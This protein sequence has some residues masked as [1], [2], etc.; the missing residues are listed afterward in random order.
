MASSDFSMQLYTETPGAC[1]CYSTVKNMT[2]LEHTHLE[3]ELLFVLEGN[4]DV[5]I[6]N[7]KIK[8]V[9]NDLIFI[10]NN[11]PHS[12]VTQNSSVS[13]VLACSPSEVPRFTQLV[14]TQGSTSCCLKSDGSLYP[15]IHSLTD[16]RVSSQN[17]YTFTGYINMLLSHVSTA[18][19]HQP[20]QAP[21][22]ITPYNLVLNYISD[23]F[24]DTTEESIA[25]E[26]GMSK[27]ALSRLFNQNMGCNLR[28]YISS[29]RINTAHRMLVQT[30]LPINEIALRCGYSSPRSFNRDFLRFSGIQPRECRNI[31]RQEKMVNYQTPIVN[32][33]LLKKW[34]SPDFT[35]YPP[36]NIFYLSPSA[37]Q[38]PA[39]S[40]PSRR[41][42]S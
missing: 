35:D 25:N 16:T 3:Y 21:R 23:H 36:E 13:L 8:A 14:Q 9:P 2:Y 38:N 6:L 28:T 22:E 19:S 10:A 42:Q 18:L 20:R 34:T 7:H 32:E 27:Y 40:R 31:E 33:I 30:D 29:I 24:E 11:V 37:P 41:L 15:I 17:L 4:I 26:L 5:A 12:Y 39:P 1:I